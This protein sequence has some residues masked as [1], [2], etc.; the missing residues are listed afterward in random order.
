[1]AAFKH[2]SQSQFENPV[3]SSSTTA[4]NF[5]TEEPSGKSRLRVL[6]LN[7]SYW[8]DAEA[9]GQLL[10]ELCEDLADRF[11]ITVL[12]GQPNQNPKNE[13]FQRTGTE[14][15]NGVTIERVLHPKWSKRNLVGRAI[16]LTG[17]LIAAIGRAFRIART[18]IVVV[19][20]D[21]FMLPLLGKWLKWWHRSRLIVYLQDLYPDVAVALGKVREGWLTK[22]IRGQLIRAYLHADAIIVLSA[23]MKNRLVQWGLDGSR[24]VCLENWVDT[25]AVYPVKDENAL[26]SREGL[27]DRFVVMHS[28]NMGLSQYLD[29]VLE[30]AGL[31]RDRPDIQFL[32]VGDGATRANLEAQ[33]R[34][35][36]LGNVRFLPYQPRD[37]LAES[38]SAANLHLISMHAEAHHCLM[39]SKLYGILASGSPVL[40][41]TAE[42][43]E[44]AQQIRNQ[45]IGLT[46]RPSDPQQ[47]AS[48][49]RW[50]AEHRDE[51]EQMGRQARLVAV[52]Q[53]DRRLQTSKFGKILSEVHTGVLERENTTPWKTTASPSV[54][55]FQ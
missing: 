50:C 11:D 7:R 26:R 53:F 3:K 49:L 51:L 36:Q 20:T 5:A 13:E 54:S 37:E 45:H 23:D 1:M 29:N 41:I 46:T 28:G 19:E 16:N 38:L 55:E 48:D 2:P 17:F 25:T 10:A 42:N 27:Q 34:R 12:A 4:T 18:D 24:I 43:S 30:A 9:T 52:E 44:L 21:P 31:L 47:L 40:A 35:M 15:H 8:P 33:A 14:R 6:F 22:L 39:P 32:L